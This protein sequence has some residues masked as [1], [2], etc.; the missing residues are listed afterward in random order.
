MEGTEPSLSALPVNLGSYEP[1]QGVT[2]WSC[3]KGKEKGTA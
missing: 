2:S 3:L 1:C